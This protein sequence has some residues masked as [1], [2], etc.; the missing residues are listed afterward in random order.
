MALGVT[1]ALPPAQ[2]NPLFGDD[3]LISI[4][5]AE[6]S[7]LLPEGSYPVFELVPAGETFIINDPQPAVSEKMLTDA[8]TVPAFVQSPLMVTR[9]RLPAPGWPS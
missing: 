7:A 4:H 2:Q 9:M 3:V 1:P 8:A 6:T 5:S